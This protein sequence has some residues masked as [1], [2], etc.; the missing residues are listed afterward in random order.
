MP[1]HTYVHPTAKAV[2]RPNNFKPIRR[3]TGKQPPPIAA[4]L[5]DISVNK[6]ITLENNKDEEEKTANGDNYEGHSGRTLVAI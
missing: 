6:E 5:D 3:L 4:Q 2:A 1:V